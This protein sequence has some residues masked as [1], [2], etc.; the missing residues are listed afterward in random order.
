MSDIEKTKIPA[1]PSR[2][3]I[4]H[5]PNWETEE[6][7]TLRQYAAIKLKVPNSGT[8]WLDKMISESLRDD[9][10]AKAMQGFLG[11]SNDLAAKAAY[12]MADAMLKARESK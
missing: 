8:Y 4:T 9:F 10:A 11:Y 3:D 7:M 6:G 1:F 12:S 2:R 5:S